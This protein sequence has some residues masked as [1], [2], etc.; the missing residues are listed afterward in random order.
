MKES[1]I[2]DSRLLNIFKA[3]LWLINAYITFPVIEKIEISLR[4]FTLT[5]AQDDTSIRTMPWHFGVMGSHPLSIVHL[6]Q[7]RVQ[8][9][10]PRKRHPP[11]S[12]VSLQKASWR[13]MLSRE[14]APGK[15]SFERQGLNSFVAFFTA[16][17]VWLFGALFLPAPYY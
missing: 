10:T 14:L 4:L 6:P 1:S 13:E 5:L 8:V 17:F 3:S 12:L 15:G 9:K 16:C 7:E 2:G 11:L